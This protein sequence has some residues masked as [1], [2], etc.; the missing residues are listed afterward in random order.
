MGDLLVF[1]TSGPFCAVGLSRGPQ[2]VAYR[3]RSMKTGQS[4]A[5]FPLI[6]EVLEE[7]GADKRGLGLIVVGTGPGNFTGTRIGVAAA[8]GLALALGIRTVGI[9]R[10]E[11]L[12]PGPAAVA[13][14]RGMAWLAVPAEA[15]RLVPVNELDAI[16]G[17]STDDTL[18]AGE[19]VPREALL[20]RMASLGAAQP[21]DA[22]LPAPLYLRPADAAPPAEAP[23]PI[24]P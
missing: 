7:A 13:A 8:R 18:E 21:E 1:D 23:P 6:A 19:T 22:P 11:A 17:L 15:P 2:L 10:L 4:E 5:L 14:H 9:S 12:G 24:L 3:C 20:A 16:D